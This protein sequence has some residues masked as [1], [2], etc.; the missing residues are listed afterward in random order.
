MQSRS[1]LYPPQHA[2]ESADNHRVGDESNGLALDANSL[3][4]L[5]ARA[6]RQKLQRNGRIA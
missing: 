5:K 3:P 2:K 6:I 1:V 4:L